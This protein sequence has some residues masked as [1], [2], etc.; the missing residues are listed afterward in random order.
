M[1]NRILL[2]VFCLFWL[3]PFGNVFSQN[4]QIEERGKT[5]GIIIGRGYED[6]WIN[7]S[8]LPTIGIAYTH[9]IHKRIALRGQVSS[10]YRSMPDSYLYDDAN[11]RIMAN[12]IVR[13]SKSP[14]L[15]DIQRDRITS[16]GLKDLDPSYTVK[17]LSVPWDF[18]V[19]FYPLMFKRHA[20]GLFVGGSLTYESHNWMRDYYPA[21]ITLDDGSVYEGTFVALNTEFN[22]LTP[23]DCIKIEYSYNFNKF[24]ATFGVSENNLLLSH[25][26]SIIFYNISIGIHAKI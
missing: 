10:F 9:P 12:I 14:F 22:S 7:L 5:L 17:T 21:D 3:S 6:G 26:S 16:I 8:K 4:T 19:L 24:L 25:R 11:G 18:G 13:D 20:L 23:G 15:D 1:T 2:Q